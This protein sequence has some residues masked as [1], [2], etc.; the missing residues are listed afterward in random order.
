MYKSILEIQKLFGISRATVRKRL[1]EL[2]ESRRYPKIA[3]IEDMG[4]LRIDLRA[5]TDFMYNRRRIKA[6]MKIE[7]YN[8]MQIQEQLGYGDF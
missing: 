5:F 8:P 3:I 6:G 1:E 4:F 7:P 2:E